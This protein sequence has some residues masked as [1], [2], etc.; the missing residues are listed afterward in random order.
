MVGDDMGVPVDNG[1]RPDTSVIDLGDGTDT[2]VDPSDRDGDGVLNSADRCPDAADPGQEDTDGDFVGDACDNCVSIA[3]ANQLDGNNDDIGDACQEGL[4]SNADTDGDTVLDGTDNCRT[5]SNLDQL[6]TDGDGFG[7]MCDTCPNS[8]NSDEQVPPVTCPGDNGNPDED[9]D[10]DGVVNTADNCPNGRRSDNGVV[11]PDASQVDGDG[12]GVGDVCDVCPMQANASQTQA[13]PS[14]CDML[15]ST[16][17]DGDTDGFNDAVDNCPAIANPTQAD[18][19]GDGYG[20]A[21]DSCPLA[22]NANQADVSVCD[23]NTAPGLDGDNDTILNQ[24]DNCVSVAN[25][26]QA[27]TDNDGRGNLCDNCPTIANFGQAD[28]NGDGVGDAC[29]PDLDN[30]LGDLDGDGDL[31]GIDNCP[32]VSNPNQTDLDFDGIGDTCDTCVCHPSATAALRNACGASCAYNDLDNDNVFAFQDN[33]PMLAN[34]IVS[35][36]GQP[37]TDGDSVGD[38]CDNCP[39][40]ANVTQDG[41]ACDDANLEYPD[42]DADGDGVTNGVD[43]C[44]SVANPLVMGV[45]VDSD[46]DGVGNACDDCDFYA[47]A[48]AQGGDPTCGGTTVQLADDDMDGVVNYLDNCSLI[49]NPG[50]TDGDA[51]GIGNACDNCVDVPS[52]TGSPNAGYAQPPQ[53]AAMDCPDL[54]DTNPNDDM[55]GIPSASDNC[56]NN[57]NPGQED[58]DGDGVG[59]VCDNCPATANP[60]QEDRYIAATMAYGAGDGIG[61][62]CQS[63]V[64]PDTA[65]ACVSESTQANPIAPNLHFVVDFSGSMDFDACSGCGSRAE[66]W[67][68]AVDTLRNTLPGNFNL[69]VSYF[70]TDSGTCGGSTGSTN[71][72]PTLA[73]AMTAAGAANL[74][75]NFHNAASIGN[76]A[77]GGTPTPAALQGVRTRNLYSLP[78]DTQAGRPSA[79]VLVTDGQ[80]TNC[81]QGWEAPGSDSNWE[82]AGATD[83]GDEIYGTIREAKNLADLGIPVYVI[84]FT[85]VNPSI[86][87]A[88][89]GAGDPSTTWNNPQTLAAAPTGTWYPVSNT[90]D[91]ID[92]LDAIR[93]TLVS[94]RLP[95][96]NTAA[97]G[98]DLGIVDVDF[99]AM[100][101]SD[102]P[103]GNCNIPRNSTNGYEFLSDGMGGTDLWLR[104]TWCNYLT[105][106]VNSDPTANVN[107]RLACS[108]TPT[109]ATDCGSDTI[110]ED[111]DGRLNNDCVATIPELCTPPGVDEDM[112]MQTDEGCFDD[113]IQGPVG[114]NAQDNNCNGTPDNQEPGVCPAGPCPTPGQTP[115]TEVCADSFDN[116]CDGMVDEGCGGMTC[117]PELCTAAGQMIDTNCDGNDDFTCQG[118]GTLPPVEL[119]GDGVDNDNDMMVDEGCPMMGCVPAPETCDGMDN[120]CDGL[121]D[122]GCPMMGCEPALEVCTDMVDN[123]CDGLVNEGCGMVCV[124]YNEVCNDSVDNDC[125]GMV[126]EGCGPICTPFIELC[127]N[128]DNDCDGV[129]DDNCV[130]CDGNQS[131]EICDGLDNDCDGL[132]DEGCP[133]AG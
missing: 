101:C 117:Q 107:V 52:A 99:T 133:D 12:D 20:N 32:S 67:D 102:S 98:A 18:T 78:G 43:N 39:T 77:G 131:N 47:N 120:D 82:P 58:G 106:K 44:I 89:A 11:L 50:Q 113:C 33:C 64:I 100:S 65:A 91:I 122:E 30:P 57:A 90:Q 6:D 127:D 75:T 19:D 36:G 80:P 126:D 34:P 13:S 21:C 42:G 8:A 132:V 94:C 1:P 2:G 60:S 5:V 54:G 92:A 95:L 124:P 125:D 63:V 9:N 56:P 109:G 29:R 83:D 40:V 115:V 116:D 46:G 103:T 129:I 48:G 23:P 97:A 123:D 14:E 37:D 53:L 17:V 38:E 88:I 66:A 68:G 61:D 71:T 108:C 74:G 114:C 85:G 3:N 69:G 111:C 112:D 118:P 4:P 104:G 81:D 73:L 22:A 72:V 70:T 26:N 86:M 41:F 51:D 121:E 76:D 93:I 130:T 105:Q 110:D 25:T 45:Q 49:A 15:P 128:V 31:N 96:G 27:D 59:N 84:G 35:M 119:C 62:H 24:N 55:D 87:A 10:M 16:G 79:V 7:D 28:A